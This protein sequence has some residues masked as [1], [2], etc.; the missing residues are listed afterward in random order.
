MIVWSWIS[1]L[2]TTLLRKHDKDQAMQCQHMSVSFLMTLG[3]L[4]ENVLISIKCTA[5]IVESHVSNLS[6]FFF[7]ACMYAW[8]MDMCACMF[9]WGWVDTCANVWMWICKLQADIKCH[10]PS[11]LTQVCETGSLAEPRAND[12]D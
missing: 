10:P 4:Q 7:C 3:F 2:R 6:S 11:L 9:V 12:S 8:Y 1:F 5:E